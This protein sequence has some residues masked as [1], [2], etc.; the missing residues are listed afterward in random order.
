MTL[1]DSL[2]TINDNYDMYEQANVLFQD[3]QDQETRDLQKVRVGLS[4]FF[5]EGE[6]LHVGLYPFQEGRKEKAVT[7]AVA[8]CAST[9]AHL[10]YPIEE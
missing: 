5:S 1:Y 7:Y 10:R 2:C 6:G 9:R 4:N 8:I 3:H